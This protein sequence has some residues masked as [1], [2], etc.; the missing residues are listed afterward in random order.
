MIMLLLY[1]I[2]TNYLDET[3]YYMSCF[4]FEA[5]HLTTMIGILLL[6]YNSYHDI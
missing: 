6:Y 1:I 5:S 2:I 3:G 4:Y